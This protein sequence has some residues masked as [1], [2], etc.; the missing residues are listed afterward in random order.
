MS[1]LSSEFDAITAIINNAGG[2]DKLVTAFKA[3]AN[4]AALTDAKN[5]ISYLV[6]TVTGLVS[7]IKPLIDIAQFFI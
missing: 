5:N 7:A 3:I 6:E 4:G 2:I 1:S